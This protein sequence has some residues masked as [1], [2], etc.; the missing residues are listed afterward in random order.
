MI[1][2]PT[3]V[4]SNV[5]LSDIK[6]REIKVI[7][8]EAKVKRTNYLASYVPGKPNAIQIFEFNGSQMMNSD[9]FEEKNDWSAGR[10][11]TV[12]MVFF[13]LFVYFITSKNT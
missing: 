4:E 2:S 7:H 5:L 1:F 9:Q 11:M 3:F 12:F 8:S 6:L 13:G 10:S